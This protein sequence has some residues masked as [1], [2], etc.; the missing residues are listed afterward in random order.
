[1]EHGREVVHVLFL[2]YQDKMQPPKYPAFRKGRLM[3]GKR[4]TGNHFLCN[5]LLYTLDRGEG[6]RL[7]PDCIL[8]TWSWTDRG[9]GCECRRSE[10]SSVISDHKLDAIVQ[11]ETEE[12][13]SENMN[14][15]MLSEERLPLQMVEQERNTGWFDDTGWFD[16]TGLFDWS[17][18][19]R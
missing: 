11:S 3:E 14:Q 10:I 19:V 18:N 2:T 16:E 1:M 13:D 7:A 6:R 12:T 9:G 5:S 15:I 8:L 4:E 17:G